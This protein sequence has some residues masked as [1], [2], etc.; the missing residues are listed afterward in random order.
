MDTGGIDGSLL[1]NFVARLEKLRG[2]ID[3]LN[4]DCGEV[5]KEAEG[6]GFDKKIINKLLRRRRVSKAQ[7]DEE[8]TLL[9]LY[10]R[11]LGDFDHTLLGQVAA[12]ARASEGAPSI[13]AITGAF[14][15]YGV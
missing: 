6:A 2:E 7:R 3:A 11:A 9:A 10:E 5:L 12:W 1:A 13:E 14:S 15:A 8:D 4:E